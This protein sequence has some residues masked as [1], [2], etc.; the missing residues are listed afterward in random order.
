MP[1]A[2]G[3]AGGVRGVARRWWLW[4]KGVVLEGVVRRSK[5]FFLNSY[6]YLEEG[7]GCLNGAVLRRG[8]APFSGCGWHLS[9][10]L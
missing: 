10:H 7:G 6:Y 5:N 4:G 1:G 3:R 2:G 9:A 8:I